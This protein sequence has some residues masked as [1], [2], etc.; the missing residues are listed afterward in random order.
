ME[1]KDLIKVT[2]FVLVNQLTW[3][4]TSRKVIIHPIRFLPTVL[5]QYK[6]P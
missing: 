3:S 2:A 4:E 5:D 1:Y 6:L